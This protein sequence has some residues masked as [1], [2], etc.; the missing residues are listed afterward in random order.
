MEILCLVLVLLCTAVI[1]YAHTP[2]P[3]DSSGRDRSRR[4]FAHRVPI[5]RRSPFDGPFIVSEIGDTAWQE[6]CAIIESYER[7]D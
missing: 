1:R 4:N 5:A 7:G 6:N 3:N 2:I